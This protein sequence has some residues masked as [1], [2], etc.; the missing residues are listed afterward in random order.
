MGEG[1]R[2]ETKMDEVK[3]NLQGDKKA[4]MKRKRKEMTKGGI[5]NVMSPV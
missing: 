1:R 3:M 4:E 2:E 5:L